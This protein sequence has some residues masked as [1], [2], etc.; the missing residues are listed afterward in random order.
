MPS[1]GN[2]KICM[3]CELSFTILIPFEVWSSSRAPYFPL[4]NILHVFLMNERQILRDIVAFW[5]TRQ[6]IVF[7]M[8]STLDVLKLTTISRRNYVLCWKFAKFCQ[9]KSQL[10]LGVYFDK[11]LISLTESELIKNYAIFCIIC[12]ILIY[13]LVLC[14]FRIV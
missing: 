1:K 14:S 13:L 7:L 5:I 10:H 6:V 9:K 2:T 3:M 8:F 11:V 12:K 4:R